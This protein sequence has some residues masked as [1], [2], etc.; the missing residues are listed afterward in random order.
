MLAGCPLGSRSGSGPPVSR[1]VPQVATTAA[2]VAPSRAE[3]GIASPQGRAAA[4]RAWCKGRSLP[5]TAVEAEGRYEHPWGATREGVAQMWTL[6]AL[7]IR[8]RS[9]R[10]TFRVH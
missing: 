10:G 3:E 6:A 9:H 4:S 8:L 1:L 2:V 7:M 5:C